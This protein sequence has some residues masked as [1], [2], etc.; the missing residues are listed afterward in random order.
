MG[1][2]VLRRELR[3]PPSL[4]DLVLVAA[5]AFHSLALRAD[6]TVVSWGYNRNGQT[7]VPV[8]LVNVVSV[9]AGEYHSLALTAEGQVVA[10][11]DNQ[12]HQTD[13]PP[14]LTGVGRGGCRWLP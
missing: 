4:N 9:A 3:V 5:G 11:G 14:S 1:E 10:W 12:Y 2:K 7:N 8:D 13:L 6:G